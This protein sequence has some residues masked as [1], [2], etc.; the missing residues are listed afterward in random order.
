LAV[1]K[2]SNEADRIGGGEEPECRMRLD[3][4]AL[5]EQ[6]Q[7]AGGFQ[8]PLDHE[9]H[10]RPPGIVL[11]EA[12]RDVVLIGPGQDA[13]AELGHLVSVLD[14][15]RVLADE[16][17]TAD[18]A[19]EVDAYARPVQPRRHLFD[20]RRF[21]GTVIAGDDHAP[22]LG[23]PGKHRKRGLAVEEIVLV[24]IGYVLVG[25][26]EGGHFH[27]GI[28]PEELTGGNRQVWNREQLFGGGSHETFPLRAIV[29]RSEAWKA[30]P[31]G[32]N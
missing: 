23:K 27:V 30:E 16:I 24:D 28:D 32:R 26:R 31:A 14:H 29:R 11:V 6:R 4:A 10:V 21:A 17:D 19:V 22:V 5:V 25:F 12:E 20:V 1:A 8:H 13:V 3:H 9:H 2:S 15:D 18:V 7:P